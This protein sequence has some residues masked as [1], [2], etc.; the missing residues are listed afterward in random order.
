MVYT[1]VYLKL[2][3]VL[4]FNRLYLVELIM[5]LF[6]Q[7]LNDAELQDLEQ[8]MG[9]CHGYDNGTPAVYQH[10]LCL[11][12]DTENT[13]LYYQDKE[14]IGILS[15]YFFYE[16]ACEAS[17][18]VAPKHRRQ[19]ISCKLIQAILPLLQA[20]QITKLIFSSATTFCD[21]WLPAKGFTYQQSEYH[22]ER[23]SYETRLITNPSL[24]LRKATMADLKVLFE[25]DEACF[26]LEST[27]MQERFTYILNNAD[28]T[29]LLASYEQTVV[30]KAHIHWREENTL[31]S[32]IAISPVYQ[33]RGFGSELIA[34]CINHVL[35]NGNIKLALD[36]ETS[37]KNALNLYIRHGFKTTNIYDYWFVSIE[38]LSSSLK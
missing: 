6:R 3:N 11:K 9:L 18:M 32:D 17:L 25:L 37:N 21:K 16:H 15:V 22:M 33:G 38:K 31:L 10:L 28:Y 5:L 20:K 30:G 14:L 19:G 12:R 1:L 26:P 27:N 36:V 24:V 2:V 29:I 8:L 34:N 13:I 4:L 35:D 23:N 7:Q